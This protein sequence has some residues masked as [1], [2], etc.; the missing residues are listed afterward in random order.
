MP[1]D[2]EVSS[3]TR[4]GMVAPRRRVGS[5]ALLEAGSGLEFPVSLKAAFGRV[6][7]S[8]AYDAKGDG[9]TG[10]G[11]RSPT[12]RG[13]VAAGGGTAVF[14]AKTYPWN[15]QI[16][17][18]EVGAATGSPRRL[19]ALGRQQSHDQPRGPGPTP[20]RAASAA[21]SST[22]ATP[23]AVPSSRWSRLGGGSRIR[24][25]PGSVHQRRSRPESPAR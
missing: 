2:L 20:A 17:T 10:A 23:A 14:A 3:A 6:L 11:P 21:L 5:D 4:P 16:R 8:E 25:G 9:T 1:C 15:G 19:Y 18:P 12:C 13:H 24:G 22:C 7:T